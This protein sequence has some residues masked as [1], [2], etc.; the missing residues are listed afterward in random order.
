M[1][2]DRR[3]DD[4]DDLDVEDNGGGA[5]R[6]HH[7]HHRHHHR[8]DGTQTVN[9]MAQASA[10]STPCCACGSAPRYLLNLACPIFVFHNA[11]LL[12]G[13]QYDAHR[14]RVEERRQ[15]GG[16]GCWSCVPSCIAAYPWQSLFTCCQ[17]LPYAC[18]VAND[19]YDNENYDGY[20]DAACSWEHLSLLTL[21]C[22]C[23]PTASYFIRN[24]T[25]GRARDR[26]IHEDMWTSLLIGCCF[27]PCS[28]QQCVDQM[29]A[30]DNVTLT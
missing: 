1:P 23:A 22:V 11:A 24:I 21:G 17:Y 2:P 30:D 28:M 9:T 5:P 18:T 26:P 3:S 16:E 20:C 4:D 7:R 13:G 12:Y 15:H 6:S 25:L 8:K 19:G 27:W 10:W 29:A 14:E